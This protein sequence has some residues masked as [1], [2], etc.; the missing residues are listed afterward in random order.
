M[1]EKE[2]KILINTLILDKHL[3]GK[4]KEG[5]LEIES[6][7]KNMNLVKRLEENLTVISQQNINMLE[8]SSGI[9]KQK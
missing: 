5:I 2:I 4:W 1:E 8:V 9:Q 7:D 6:E 3:D